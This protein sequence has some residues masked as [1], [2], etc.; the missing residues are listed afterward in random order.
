MVE[1]QRFIY[2]KVIYGHQNGSDKVRGFI[3]VPGGYRNP[4][5][6]LMG[7]MGHSGE[8]EGCHRR[9]ARLPPAQTELDK[10][11]GRPPFLI[12]L[13]PSPFPLSVG[14]RGANPT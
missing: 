3:E 1:R 9:G 11:W 8:R 13:P 10:E 6:K 14:R 12:P 5:G 4:L 2:W 7:L